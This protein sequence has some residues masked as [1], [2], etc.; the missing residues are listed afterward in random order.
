LRDAEA[1]VVPKSAGVP[2]A[3]KT[4]KKRPGPDAAPEGGTP[5]P[6]PGS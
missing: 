1:E 5:E 4:G 3:G 6:Q 2:T